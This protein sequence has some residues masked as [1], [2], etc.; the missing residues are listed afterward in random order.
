MTTHAQGRVRRL[1]KRQPR[2]F[3]TP[4]DAAADL[5]CRRSTIYRYCEEGH[6]FS[7]RE[8]GSRRLKICAKSVE[9]Y[10]RRIDGHLVGSGEG[11]AA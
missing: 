5:N 2:A 8:P 7:W 6:L 1:P 4:A 3:V 11:E 10:G 9:D